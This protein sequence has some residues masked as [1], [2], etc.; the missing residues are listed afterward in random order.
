VIVDGHRQDALRAFL[1]DDIFI[2]DFL[3]FLRLGELVAGALG[4]L[5]Q[6]FPDY[7]VAKLDAFVADENA[8]AGDELSN[9]VLALPTE[10]TVQQL[11]VIMFA[12][13]IFAHAVLKL[14]APRAS[15]RPATQLQ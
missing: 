14:A 5:L 10:R 1:T 6:L 13:R 15:G 11:A 2:E 8:R 12:A 4:A 9:L 7:V 3:D